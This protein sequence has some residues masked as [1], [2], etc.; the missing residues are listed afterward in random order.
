MKRVAMENR[1]RGASLGDRI[2]VANGSWTRL[3][4]LLGRPEPR[5]GEGLLIIPCRGVHMF[6]MRYPLDVILLDR[7]GRVVAVYPDLRPWR[8]TRIHRDAHMALELPSG[9][10]EQSG[11]RVG[12]VVECQV[13]GRVTTS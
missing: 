11:T 4:G 5:E 3:R 1:S 13:A 6:G 10:L 7:E 9:A 8:K 2:A 12:D